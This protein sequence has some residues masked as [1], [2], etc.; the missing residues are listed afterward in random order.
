MVFIRGYRGERSR[1]KWTFIFIA[2]C[3]LTFFLEF[4]IP[5]FSYFSF[6]P[7]YALSRPWTFVTSIFLHAGFEHLFFNMFA[8]FMFGVYLESILTDKQFL[9]TFFSAGILGNVAYM[10]TSPFGTIP[11]VGASGAIY[12]IM[13]LLAILRPSLI[14]Y[15]GYM[16]MPMIV[17]AGFWTILNVLGMFVPGNIAHESHLSGLFIGIIYGIYLRRKRKHKKSLLDLSGF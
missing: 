2:I 16:P 10:L 13:G 8:L 15:V 9:L 14:V 6:V 5:S 17:A 11:A 12:G 1:P 3:V 7:A 4:I